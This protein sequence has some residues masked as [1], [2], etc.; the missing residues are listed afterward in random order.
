MKP[1][2]HARLAALAVACAMASPALAQ[3]VAHPPAGDL[4]VK[5]TS[6]LAAPM[7]FTAGLPT[8]DVMINGKGPFKLGFDT[9]SMGGAHLNAA[10]V[11]KLGLKPI[12]EALAGDPSGKNPQH[13]DIFADINVELAGKILSVG[14]SSAP[15]MATNK[16]AA[17]DGIVGPELVGAGL[18]TID[19]KNARFG[20]EQAMLPAPDGKTI[21][22]YSGFIPRVP[23]DVEG[24]KVEAYLDTG[25][26]RA[27]LILTEAAA[28]KLKNFA[29][30][31]AAGTAHT[32]ANAIE[33]KAVTLAM[34]PSIGTASLPISDIQFPSV[35][36]ANV[37]SAALQTMVVRV[38][39]KNHRVQVT[40][41]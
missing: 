22:S 24:Q 28:S 13:I 8:L 27:G 1:Q 2:L 31:I 11:E 12:G 39:T 9:G 5:I 17:L 4:A 6:P 41:G 14:A 26:V 20:F 7:T 19:Y 3:P 35:G 40:P 33:M 21:F 37:G 25:N 29:S 18:L 38:D 30:A 32:V 36:A 23:V 15:A 10:A 34:P 16:L